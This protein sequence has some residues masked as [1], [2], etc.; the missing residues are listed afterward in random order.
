MFTDIVGYT[1]MMGKDEEAALRTLEV[2][3]QLHTDA[4]QAFHGTLLKELGDGIMAVFSAASDA[5]LCAKKI[6]E[7]H[8]KDSNI[9]LRIGIHLGEVVFEESDVFGDGVNI[10]SRIEQLSPAGGIYISE[11]V[12]RNVENKKEIETVFVGEKLLK[13]VKHPVKLYAVKID[14]QSIHPVSDRMED[15]DENMEKSIAILPFVNMSNDPDQDYFCDGLCEEL[16]NSLAQL[17]KFKVASRTSSF[18]F[19]GKSVDIFEVGQTLRVDN[20]LEGSV[21]R[22]KNRI[23]ITVQL[24]SVR[25]GYHLWSERYDRE[26]ADIFDIQDEIALAIVD[27]LRLKLLGSEKK[28]MLKRGTENPEAYQLYLR[29]R[30]HF[31]RFTPDDFL[32]AIGFY[33]AAIAVDPTYAKAFAGVASCYLNLWHFDMMPPELSRPQ[34]IEAT[35]KAVEFDD[36]IAESHIAMARLKFWYEYNPEQAAKEF[37][38]VIQYNPNIPDAIAH[39]GFVMACL[40]KK[41]EALALAVKACELDPFSPM[42]NLDLAATLWLCQ[43]LDSMYI[44]CTKMIDIFP[45]FW[46][47]FYFL[48]YCSWSQGNHARAITSFQ[49]A[50]ELQPTLWPMAML[51]CLYGIVGE[52]EK[53]HHVLA[54][55]DSVT[56]GAPIANFCYALVYGGLG[57]IDK[58]LAFLEQAGKE[59]TGHLIFFDVGFRAHRLIPAFNDNPRL[60]EFVE[61]AGIPRSRFSRASL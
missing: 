28:T 35:Q 20:V 29:G 60:E 1:A 57:E 3:R 58:A 50:I 48:G 27:S 45:G 46:G 34:M 18:M 33:K 31:H 53:A 6:Q 19:K 13:N 10:A 14:S 22:S 4:I 59:R 11:S 42:T 38:K 15:S 21:R 5:V 2:N 51:G 9:L 40:G 30:Q 16:L 44:R 25:D 39:Y 61:R 43:D 23:R 56:G 41:S 32:K 7:T 47:G 37:D 52:H 49:K 26:L 17:D 12:L 54:K 24:I 36:Q 55:M 8:R